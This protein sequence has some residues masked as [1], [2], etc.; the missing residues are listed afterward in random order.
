MA[1]QSQGSDGWPTILWIAWREGETERLEPLCRHHREHVF[2]QYPASAH[3]LGRR[4][5]WCTM[6]NAQP[7]RTTP[8]PWLR[9]STTAPGG[10]KVAPPRGYAARGSRQRI[11]PI[12]H[13]TSSPP[14][15]GQE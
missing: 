2:K 7:R 10:P 12:R 13:S 4:G 5:D 11:S 8:A 14:G 3:G 6:C 9:A 1:R 15:S